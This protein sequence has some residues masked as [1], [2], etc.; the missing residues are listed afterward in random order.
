MLSSISNLLGNHVKRR[1]LFIFILI[2]VFLTYLYNNLE[3]S[4]KIYRECFL[5]SNQFEI[6]ENE[7]LTDILNSDVKPSNGKNI[8]F[9]ETSCISE[10][11]IVNL[12][13][14]QACAIE[15][16]ARMNPHM[17]VFALFASKVGFKNGKKTLIILQVDSSPLIIATFRNSHSFT[18]H[19]C[20]SS[21]QEYPHEFH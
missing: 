8:F 1:F 9:H 11:G 15:S 13:A 2:L 3:P 5:G 7:T 17:N 10:N 16:A 14:R 12:N 21:V 4:H 18:N 19:S 6:N 20:T